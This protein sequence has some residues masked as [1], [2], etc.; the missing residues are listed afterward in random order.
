M[1]A[2]NACGSAY[3]D[4]MN[5]AVLAVR[6]LGFPWATIDPFLFCVHHDDAYPAGNEQRGPAASLAGRRIGMDFEGKDGWRMYHGDVVP[7]FPQHPHRGFE[8]VT[9]VR[10]GVIDHADSLGAAAR[11]GNGDVQWLTAGGGIVHSEMFPLLDE[12]GPNP[13]EL[14]QIWL[15][16]PS[17]G[18]LSPA[19]FSMLWEHSIPR[20]RA[21]DAAQRITEIAIIA[22][23]LEN[24]AAPQPPPHSWAA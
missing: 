19:H 3:M 9:I 14:F 15:N 16:L 12:H 5:S 10:R 18:K 7:G 21:A 2:G 22:G 11:F 13:L 6:P 17:A 4:T 24:H 20:Q 23:K 1:A 8:T